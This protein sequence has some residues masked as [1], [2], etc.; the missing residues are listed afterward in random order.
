MKTTTAQPEL[1]PGVAFEEYLGWPEMSQSVLKEGRASMAHL[2]AALDHERTKVPTDDMILGTALH[3]AFLE[4]EMMPQKVVRWDG[5]RRAGREWEAFKHDHAGKAIL[6]PGYHEKLIG[7]VRSLRRHP[8][9]KRWV[10]AIEEVEVSCRGLVD[11][12][13]FKGRIDALTPDPIIDLMKVNSGDIRD[14]R[15]TAYSFGYHIQAAIY[16]ELF[17][18]GRFVLMT[19]EDSPPYDVVPFELSPSFME[20]GW[21]EAKE[22]IARVRECQG[23]GVWPGRSN[24]IAKLDEPDWLMGDAVP[25][26]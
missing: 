24:G 14:M 26:L 19:V 16:T 3:V 18:R 7:M 5:P 6:T 9:V 11:G 13:P 10:G 1:C 8:E 2:K 4:P 21:T 15:R 17:K 25:I 23:S 20:R 12:M 22:L